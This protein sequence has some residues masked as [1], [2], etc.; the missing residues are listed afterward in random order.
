[1]SS[2]VFN[3]EEHEYF[4]IP[5]FGSNSQ[6]MFDE[7]MKMLGLGEGRIWFLND[8]AFEH[9]TGVKRESPYM[10]WGQ[11][12][13]SVSADGANYYNEEE[14]FQIIEAIVADEQMLR[15]VV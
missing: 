15:N 6:G 5:S 2:R 1:M 4:S 7:P 9:I 13:L 8:Q 14:A 10:D 11:C 12:I 3:F